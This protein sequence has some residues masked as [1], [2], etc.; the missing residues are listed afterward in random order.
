MSAP[1]AFANIRVF[2]LTRRNKSWVMRWRIAG[3]DHSRSF[4]NKALAEQA[5]RKM[6]RALE[7]GEDFDT[8]TGMPVSWGGP[9]HSLLDFA[10]KW[11]DASFDDWSHKSRDTH[12]QSLM[13]LLP[14][15]CPEP[16]TGDLLDA[17]RLYICDRCSLPEFRTADEAK[18]A[19]VALAGEWLHANCR[20]IDA[21]TPK[22]LRDEIIPRLTINLDG[23]TAARPTFLKRKN[24]LTAMLGDAFGDEVI[25]TNPISGLRRRAGQCSE[26]GEVDVREI[27]SPSEYRQLIAQVASAPSGGRM[28]AFLDFTL[29]TG[30]RPGEV[31]ALRASDLELPDEGWGTAVLSGSFT[32]AT[33]RSGG[34]SKRGLKAR[35]SDSRRIVNLPPQ[36]VAVLRRHLESWPPGEDGYVFRSKNGGLLTTNQSRLVARARRQL[37]WVGDH[38]F[39]KVTHYTG[40][41]VFISALIYKGMTPSEIA[42]LCGNSPNVVTTVY[43]QVFASTNR[44]T[45]TLIADAL[46]M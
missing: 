32:E 45:T 16:P 17:V 14:A 18:Q 7:D 22:L 23:A 1:S 38:P 10:F 3:R 31:S 42:L 20:K 11:Y 26:T 15:C 29:S 33:A 30:A 43:A 8:D 34:V 41:H 27:P 2:D 35:S 21:L 19:E 5:R 44:D 36:L 6:I 46:A 13:A 40:R 28:E 4:K 24:T 39:A 37:G 25:A 9:R 12:R